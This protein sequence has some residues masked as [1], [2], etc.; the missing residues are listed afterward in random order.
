MYSDLEIHFEKISSMDQ[1][2]FQ[3]SA[4]RHENLVRYYLIPNDSKNYDA[5]MNIDEMILRTIRRRGCWVL[6]I[7]CAFVFFYL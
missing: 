2:L 7:F 1:C 4:F 6:I 3:F 5:E